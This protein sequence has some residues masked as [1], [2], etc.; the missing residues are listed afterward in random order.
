MHKG[1][2]MGAEEQQ[3][4]LRRGRYA[5]LNWRGDIFGGVTTAV[6]SLPLA[7]AF[8]VASGAGPQAGLYGAVFVGLFA[9]IF[10]GTRTLISE[11]TGP[12]TV[13]MTAVITTL[14]AAN[15]DNGLA[16]A[17]SVV[18]VAGLTQIVF[19]VLKLGRYITIMPY[20]V[21]SGFMS[22]IGILL[23]LMQLAPLLGQDP[24]GGGAIGVMSNIPALIA[25]ADLREVTL[26]G[27]AL[28]VLFGMPRKWRQYCPPHLVALV[29]GTVLAAT[30]FAGE[31]LR[32]IGEIPM[33]LPMPQ[34]PVLTA[35]QMR[36]ILV[37]GMIL[38]L[39]GC[40][41][42]LLTAMIADSLTREQHD[43]NRELV[44]QGIGNIV[45]GLFGGLPG[46]GATMGTVV[47]IQ[48]GARSPMA[49]IIRAAILLLVVL[50][51]APL[52]ESIPM[53][54]LAAIALKVG[55]DI[56]DWSFLKRA[57]HVS[58]TATFIMYGV[59][60][61]TVFVDLVVAVGLG[62]FIANIL[63]IERLSKLQA[64]GVRTIDTSDDDLP[65][66]DRERELFELGKGHI[67]LLHLSGPMIFGVAKAISRE[68]EALRTKQ[69][70][71]LILDLKD[72]PIL[73][74]T[75]ALALENVVLEARK[76]GVPVFLAQASGDVRE[77]F[78]RLAKTRPMEITFCETR[79]EALECALETM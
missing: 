70:R 75:V 37:E 62:V 67:I 6:I 71:V 36:T 19:G 26:A 43:S 60:A 5:A 32:R 25:G 48:V 51:I 73:S 72:V 21:I 44:G 56:L 78:E 63:T 53:A 7:L 77:R 45:S 61:L 54:V 46:A 35:E 31:D 40:I 20:S 12:M 29:F 8:G 4:W 10:G 15:P 59:M 16:M 76:A 69:G 1:S 27:F 17:F 18:I 34:L 22:G 14:I 2:P 65:L 24:P 28:I 39:L 64:E 74:T 79:V 38:G 47:N 42:S 52:L 50:V 68:Q 33:G 58:L 41:D 11:P 30:V 57:H 55:V 3:S 49:G 66:D 23:V 9:A 13:I